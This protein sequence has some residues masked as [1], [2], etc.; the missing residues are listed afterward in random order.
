MTLPFFFL[1]VIAVADTQHL[2]C[3]FKILIHSGR[4]DKKP[5]EGSSYPEVSGSTFIGMIWT[6]NRHPICGMHWRKGG[7]AGGNFSPT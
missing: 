4:P 2:L 5:A 7:N 6:S 3:T 1:P